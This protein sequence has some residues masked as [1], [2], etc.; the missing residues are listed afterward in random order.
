MR[1][2]TVENDPQV[3][4]GYDAL[5]VVAPDT[6]SGD[7][8]ALVTL[9]TP[10]RRLLWGIAFWAVVLSTVVAFLLPNHYKA[11]ARVLP[12]QPSSSQAFSALSQLSGLMAL[13]GKDLG[14]KNP[15]DLYSGVLKSRGIADQ[16][17][18]KFELQKVYRDRRMV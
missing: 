12:A 13:A 14:V 15:S 10:Y 7:F 17:I 16:L 8:L 11:T 1:P 4:S 3:T 2:P 18:R 5:G 9:L 6:P